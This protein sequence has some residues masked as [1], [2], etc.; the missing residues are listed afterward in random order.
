MSSSDVARISELNPVMAWVATGAA[1][2]GIILLIGYLI[3]RPPLNGATKLG[4]FFALGVLP[5]IAMLVGNVASF[6]HSSKRPFCGSCHVMHPYTDDSADPESQTLAARHARNDLFGN[7]NCYMCHQDYGMFGTIVTKMGGMRHVW[8]YY[9]EYNE[10]SI[11]EA[12][13][14][15]ELYEPYTNAACMNCHSTTLKGYL[16]IGAHRGLLEEVRSGEASCVSAGCHGPAHPFSKTEEELE[17]S[18]W[19]HP[20]AAVEPEETEAEEGGE[21]D[22]G[23]K[24]ENSP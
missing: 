21:E 8:E 1:I 7:K 14:K 13:E 12:L 2:L 23:M 17:T 24:L 18:A 10:Y 9:T 19:V 22:A 20:E 15:I 3:H 11:E 6:Q 4:L 16:E 5:I